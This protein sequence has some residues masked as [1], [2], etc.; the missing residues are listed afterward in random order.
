MSHLWRHRWQALLNKLQ[1]VWD[2]FFDWW[3]LDLVFS[4][5][6]CA[7]VVYL[8]PDGS[9][10]DSLGRLDLAVRQNLYTDMLQ[11]ATIFAGFSAVSFSIFL[12]SGSTYVARIRESA[13]GA[14]IIQLWVAAL[15]L[16]WVSAFVI[17]AAKI[18][19]SGGVYSDNPARWFAVSSI[20]LIALQMIRLVWVLHKITHLETIKASPA[21]KTASRMPRIRRIERNQD[22][23]IKPESQSRD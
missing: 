4:V 20:F 10:M 12:A 14:K 6:F 21:R 15:S 1:L 3:W 23:S 22:G 18:Y 17:I 8:I 9:K 16:P 11:L 13:T 19:D 7:S 2:K 5:M